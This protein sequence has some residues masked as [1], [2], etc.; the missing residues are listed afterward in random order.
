MGQCGDRHITHDIQALRM[1]DE[2]S[3]TDMRQS[4]IDCV[5][6]NTTVQQLTHAR[7]TNDNNAINRWNQ[8][9]WK[10][11]NEELSHIQQETPLLGETNTQ[12][13]NA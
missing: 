3:E 10:L 4:D 6:N 9:R 11:I 8:K 13:P 1:N 12:R 7:I 2:L 5:K